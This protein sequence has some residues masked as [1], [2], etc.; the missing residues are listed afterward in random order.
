MLSISKWTRRWENSKHTKYKNIV[1]SIFHKKLTLR[2]ILLK[3][4]SR[5]GF[6]KIA[7]LKTGHSV[8]ERSQKQNWHWNLPRML[9]LQS[10]RDPRTFS[11]KLQKIWHRTSKTRKGYKENLLQKQLLQIEH[12]YRWSFRTV[13]SPISRCCH[14]Q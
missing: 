10:E 3:N 11:F 2:I 8:P 4:T 9:H 7:R 13:W 6:S 14:S 1:P 5:K 12:D